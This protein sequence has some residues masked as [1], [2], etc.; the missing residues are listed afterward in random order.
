MVASVVVYKC[1]L[2]CK[3]KKYIPV[4]AEGC[5]N[6]LADSMSIEGFTRLRKTTKTK[7]HI[8]PHTTNM[9][10]FNT[11]YCYS[12]IPHTTITPLSRQLLMMGVELPETR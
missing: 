1:D 7:E 6:R 5:Q 9:P 8:D 3:L 10:E 12:T 4:A 11:A 2:V